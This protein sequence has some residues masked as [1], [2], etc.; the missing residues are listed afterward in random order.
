MEL[1]LEFMVVDAR[2]SGGKDQH[3]AVRRLERQ[4]FCDPRAR[5]AKGLLGV[6]PRVAMLSFSTHGSAKHE[7][8]DKVQEATRLVKEKA[9]DILVDGELQLDAALIPTVQELK[10][11]DSPLKGKANILIFP[12]VQAGNI[13]YKLVRTLGR[14]KAIGP[15]CQGFASPINDL[16]RSCSVE[17]IISMVAVTAVQ[18]QAQKR[19]AAKK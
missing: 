2:I 3:A 19:N 11:P 5:N 4:R 14:A 8:V 6:E 15:V 18:A 16:S 1:F 7:L 10:A 12:D 9:P 17:D 13:G